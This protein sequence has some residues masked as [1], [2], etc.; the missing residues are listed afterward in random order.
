VTSPQTPRRSKRHHP[1]LLTATDPSL[2]SQL[3]DD[4]WISPPLHTRCTINADLV[5]DE[6]STDRA[7]TTFYPDFVRSFRAADRVG[8]AASVKVSI[9]D[10]VL[11]ATN[12]TRPSIG[13][14]IAL[15]QVSRAVTDL[16]MLAMV[17]WFLRPTELAQLRVKREHLEVHLP[18]PTIY[19]CRT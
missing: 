11:L 8:N 6:Q 13:V 4:K 14:I 2:F 15:W 5:D 9:G 16:Q 19:I 3:R 17:H 18:V 1:T 7:S 10:T 12:A